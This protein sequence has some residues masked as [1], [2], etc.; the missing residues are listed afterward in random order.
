MAIKNLAFDGKKFDL[1][2]ELINPTKTED[3]LF[4]HGWGSN[5]D[6]MKSAFSSHLKEYRHI[7]L[8]MPGFGK[9]SNNY[10][11]TTKEY[12][13][14][15]KEFL[16]SINSNCEIVFGHSFGGKVA[17]LLNPKNLVLL[18]SAGILEEKSTNVKFKIF[19]AKLLNKLGLKNFTKIFR[20]KDVDKMSENM[21][22][23]FKN[24]VDEDFS[25]YFSNFQ[26]SAFV[27][28]GKE[29]SA[30][31]LKSGEKIANLIKKSTFTSYNGDH[32]FFLKH[33]KNICERVENGI[34]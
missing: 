13:K 18:S 6:I 3:I 11:L 24:V 27:F 19:F 30:T 12:S 28:W 20:S 9:S 2:Y 10:I 1:S 21:Y 32:Y 8:D 29:D 31:S 23:T 22:A 17:T 4:L 5:K 14:I 33:S 16:N 7:Y 15:I 34:S 25:S 26:N